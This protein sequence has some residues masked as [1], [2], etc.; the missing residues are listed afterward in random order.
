MAFHRKSNTEPQN[1]PIT[2]WQVESKSTLSQ[3]SN[4]TTMN[5]EESNI[6]SILQILENIL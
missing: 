5:L 1:Q 4:L 3:L 2:A 6:V